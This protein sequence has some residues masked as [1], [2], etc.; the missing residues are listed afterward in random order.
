MLRAM[1]HL[2]ACLLMVRGD[3]PTLELYF[4]VLTRPTG[5]HLSPAGSRIVYD[6]IM[7]VIEGNWPDQTPEILPMVFPSWVD[8]PK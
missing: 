6:E 4:S 5:L 1:R 8:A 3:K 2:L 7:K